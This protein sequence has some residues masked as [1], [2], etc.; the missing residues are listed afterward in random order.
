MGI[1][2]N[3]I[4]WIMLIAGLSTCSMLAAVIAPQDALLSMYGANLTEPLADV[5]VRSWAFLIFLMGVMLIYGAYRPEART[6]CIV[7]AGTSKLGFIA[8]NLLFGAQFLDAL[9]LT[10]SFDGLVVAVLATYLIGSPPT[11]ID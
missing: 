8:L 3:N 7:I 9:T 5:V 2:N 1:I 11:Q 4:K 6:L 10:M